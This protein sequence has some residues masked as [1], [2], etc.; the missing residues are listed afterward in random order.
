MTAAPFVVV[1]FAAAISLAAQPPGPGSKGKIVQVQILTN[2]HAGN[3]TRCAN[4]K[5]PL[6]PTAILVDADGKNNDV[7]HCVDGKLL[8]H[9]DEKQQPDVFKR[10]LVQ[11]TARDSI[12]WVA[13]SPFRVVEIRRHV[14]AGQKPNPNAPHYPFL[15]PL[16][17]NY[18]TTVTVGP[19]L[20]L[21]D[22]VVQQ[23]K[24][25]FEFQKFGR[26]DPDFVCSM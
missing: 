14:D 4:I 17:S 1:L 20:D 8:S 15:E 5:D 3:E 7:H 24:V 22:V 12:Q 13:T 26:V 23:Y 21:T 25:N 10:T 11:L 18:A 9:A 19:V 2:S 16:S 6:S